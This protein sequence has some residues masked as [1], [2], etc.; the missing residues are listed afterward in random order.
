MHAFVAQKRLA[1][2]AT[3]KMQNTLL[4]FKIFH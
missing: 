2:V 4:Q 3:L 1:E